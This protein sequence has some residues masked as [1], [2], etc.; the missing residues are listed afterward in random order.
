MKV[1][2]LRKLLIG[3]DDSDDVI[4]VSNNF[5]L[6]GSMVNA[7]PIV[8]MYGKTKRDFVDAFDRT[9]YTK[10]VYVSDQENGKR[11]LVIYG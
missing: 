11:T 5:E 1:G 7:K 3:L 4:T 10:E 6:A 9:P 2:E 8:G